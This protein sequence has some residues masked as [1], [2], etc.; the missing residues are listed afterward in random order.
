MNTYKKIM[1]LD[2]SVGSENIGDYIIMDAVKQELRNIFPNAFFANVATHDNIGV[3]A[4]S[5]HES[6]DYT[7]VGGTNLLSGMY[8]GK[9]RMLWKVGFRESQYLNDVI[10]LGVGWSSYKQYDK[11]KHLPFVL[12]QKHLY[13]RLFDPQIYHSVRDSYTQKRLAAYGVNSIN[14]ACVTM[15]QLTEEHLARIPRSKSS[16]AVVTITDYCNS[17]EYV[18]AYKDMIEI[19]LGNYDTVFLWLQSLQDFKI[20][21][22][23]HIK[24]IERIQILPPNLGVFNNF[25]AKGGVDYIGTRLHGGIR[26]LQ[27]GNRA[28]IIEVDNRAREIAKDTNLPTLSYKNLNQL[29]HWINHK[30]QMDIRVPFDN[31]AKWRA[32]FE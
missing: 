4:K 26:A 6:S 15:W 1:L 5:I 10:G 25:L 8:L 14:T 29:D 7:F 12:L 2:T 32:Q 13:K 31:I 30:Q 24:N 18:S 9:K 20:L 16:T 28:L 3:Q 19:V 11:T 17:D 21:N 23:L 22:K 27:K